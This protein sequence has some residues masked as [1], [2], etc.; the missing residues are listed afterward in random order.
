MKEILEKWGK[1]VI[2]ICPSEIPHD[3]LF[4]PGAESIQKV[5]FDTYDFSPCDLFIVMDT[6]GWELVFSS[7]N[8][9]PPKIPVIVIDNHETNISFGDVN[10]IDLQTSSVAEMLYS[11]YH[12]WEV[13]VDQ[14]V[15]SCLMAG[16]LG[17]TG[18]FQYEVHKDTFRIANEL[19]DTGIDHKSIVFFLFNSKPLGQLQF[20]GEVI[21]RMKVE[22]EGFVWA[23]IPYDVYQKYE[24]IS[25]VRETA[26]TTVIR[27]L[28][29]THF[30]F[31]LT[32]DSPGA[33][34]MS[35]R[36]RTDFDVAQLALQVGNG[37]GHPAAS[38]AHLDGISFEKAVEKVVSLSK[39]LAIKHGP[40]PQD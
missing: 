32:E 40:P 7:K 20:W 10:L 14:K 6:S 3:L 2:I 17:D 22:P 30:G 29:G 28:E 15:A 4:I 33:I 21:S 26:A 38:G 18:S 23:A 35:F 9:T 24:H 31:V 19:L 27:K 1:E 12:D 8:F 25:G 36:S 37:G 16:I 5:E 34:T 13:V 39:E 11:I